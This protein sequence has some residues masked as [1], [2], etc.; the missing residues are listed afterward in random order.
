MG[1]L[2]V[3]DNVVAGDVGSKIRPAGWLIC[4]PKD[5]VEFEALLRGF[6]E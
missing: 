5:G 2:P 6:C 3:V 1:L 4:C